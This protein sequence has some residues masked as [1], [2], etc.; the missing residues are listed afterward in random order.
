MDRFPS[1]EESV[2]VESKE[3]PLLENHLLRSDYLT[4]KDCIHRNEAYL[5]EKVKILQALNEILQPCG[6]H[7]G[8]RVRD[9]FCFYLLYNKIWE[10]LSEDEAIDF[11]IMQ[12]ILPRIQ[13]NSTEIEKMLEK[14]IKFCEIQYPRSRAKCEF[15]LGRFRDD[16]FTS[17]WL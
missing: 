2:T 6:L 16:G 14:L 7:V 8:Y 10:L 1:V 17:F 5:H 3:T 12:K 9:E 15:M 11:Q 13:G 4:L